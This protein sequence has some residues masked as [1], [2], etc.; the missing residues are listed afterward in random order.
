MDM[1]RPGDLW[2]VRAVRCKRVLLLQEPYGV[3]AEEMENA[4]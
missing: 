1:P 2:A 4:L 3:R